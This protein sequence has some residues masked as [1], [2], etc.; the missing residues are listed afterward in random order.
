MSPIDAGW[1]DQNSFMIVNPVRIVAPHIKNLSYFLNQGN[2]DLYTLITTDAD[3]VPASG[4]IPTTHVVCNLIR[5]ISVPGTETMVFTSAGDLISTNTSGSS[6]RSVDFAI[7]P[8]SGE[9]ESSPRHYALCE[10]GAQIAPDEVRAS[11]SLVL[12]VDSIVIGLSKC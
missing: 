8:K 7:L 3:G 1:I 10:I 11:A 12:D 9:I 6:L 5:S 2:C 4:D